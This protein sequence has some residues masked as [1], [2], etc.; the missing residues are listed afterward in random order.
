MKLNCGTD[1]SL[2]SYLELLLELRTMGFR[3]GG[4]RETIM[5]A[6]DST[7]SPIAVL[8][9]DVDADLEA[10]LE[11][12]KAEVA[13]N[14][15]STYLVMIQ[16]PVYNLFS[17]RNL[18]HVRAIAGLGH[19]IGLHFDFQYAEESAASVESQ[20]DLQAHFLEQM[21]RVEIRT[22]SAHQPSRAALD[23]SHY[24]GA[25]ISCYT[26]PRLSNLHYLS[27]S[28]RERSPQSLL[29]EARAIHSRRRRG[30]N[31]LHLLIHPMWWTY[32]E[33]E[34]ADVWDAVLLANARGEQRQLLETERAFGSPREFSVKRA[35]S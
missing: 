16:S 34:A 27:D 18:E 30:V 14:V 22:Y 24:S 17:R 6:Q 1:W 12:A 25:L 13:M 33:S 5:T 26:D 23:A 35:E 10:A 28:S 11:M 7:G 29:S 8:R 32:G 3:T 21:L 31:G 9:H 19:E 15:T 2:H 4:V 20:I